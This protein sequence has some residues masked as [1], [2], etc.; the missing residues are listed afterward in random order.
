MKLSTDLA[1][2]HSVVIRQLLDLD[3]I[4][5]WLVE[6][7]EDMIMISIMIIILLTRRYWVSDPRRRTYLT[8]GTSPQVPQDRLVA[9]EGAAT[10]RTEL[11]VL[12]MKALVILE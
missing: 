9:G 12:T 3:R 4:R 2:R 1:C 7:E 6:L 10:H 5:R 11:G 8:A